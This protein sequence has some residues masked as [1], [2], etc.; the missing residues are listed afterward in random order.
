MID[1][2]IRWL[3]FWTAAMGMMRSSVFSAEPLPPRALARIGSHRFYHGPGITCVALS[4]DGRRAASAARMPSSEDGEDIGRSAYDQLIVMWDAATGERIHELHVPQG[5]VSRLAFSPEGKRLAAS[6]S[7]SED[8]SEPKSGIVLFDV[9]TGALVRRL[10]EFQA[11]IG[12]LQFSADGKQLRVSEWNGPVS[13]WDAATGIRLRLWKPPPSKTLNK[14]TRKEGA[15]EGVMSPDGRV[16]VW[17]MACCSMG[18]CPSVW[19]DGLRVHDAETNKMLFRKKFIDPDKDSSERESYHNELNWSF[20]FT[21]DGKRLMADGDD[22]LLVWEAATGRELKTIKV[23][24]MLRFSQAPDGR[25]AVIE[26]AVKDRD[27][28]RLRLWDIEAGKPL[29]ELLPTF[30][31]VKNAVG[32][33]LL[34]FASNGKTLLIATDSTLRLFDARTGEERTVPGH[35]APVTARFST[36]GRTLFTACAQKRW[37]WNISRKEPT[38]L[39]PEPRKA[40]E[41]DCLDQSVDRQLLLHLSPEIARR[42]H[43]RLST[44]MAGSPDKRLVA[45]AEKESGLVRVVEIASGKMRAEFAGHRHG[46][47]SLAFSPDGKTLASGGEDN[48]VFIWDVTGT[49]TLP[50]AAE[51]PA[52]WWND[53]A[54]DDSQRA[55]IAIAALLRKPEASVAFLR[56]KLRPEEAVSEKRL[57]QLIADLDAD[58]YFTR[59]S[60]SRE[61]TRLGKR[62]EAAL[63]RRLTNRP[64]LEMRRR[65]EDILGKL[66]PNPP[67]LETLQKLRAI[68]VL[69][70]VNMPAA[71]RCLEALAKGAAEARQ[72]REAK[73][74]LRRLTNH[75]APG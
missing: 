20:A 38:L 24:G 67:P 34:V 66:E 11:E 69:E 39:C 41:A 54:S 64:T 75:R 30:D 22:K 2:A 17:E 23:P 48:V 55:G 7:I 65:I 21:S 27:H 32:K 1:Q 52:S 70:H 9:E 47:R 59:E 36:D 42:V 37:S 61:L 46:V 28:T 29:R 40:W 6:Y 45:I 3:V 43:D 58:A 16:I 51:G 56:A 18:G 50:A 49:K 31:N 13:A 25:Y 57:A 73:A 4:P 19:M 71:R 15:V 44:C 60:A 33:T 8:P 62:A 53:L 10:S 68:E 14:G 63:R 5:A 35:R 72:T 74:A 12:F 26:E